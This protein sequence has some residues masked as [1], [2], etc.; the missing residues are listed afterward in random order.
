[1]RAPDRAGDDLGVAARL[2]QSGRDAETG[3]VEAGLLERRALDVVARLGALGVVTDP[4]LVGAVVPVD[5]LLLRVGEAGAVVDVPERRAARE[6]E[7]ATV[8][9]NLREGEQAVPALQFEEVVVEH[10]RRRAPAAR[11]HERLLRRVPLVGHAR[12]RLGD[13]LRVAVLDDLVVVGRLADR[14]ERELLTQC[15]RGPAGG[16]VRLDVE[17]HE[18]AVQR[19]SGVHEVD[20][21]AVTQAGGVVREHDRPDPGGATV[22][23][24]R[25]VAA[26]GTAGEVDP[27]RAATARGG[28]DLRLTLLLRLLLAVAL[29]VSLGL[30]LGGGGG[31]GV[32][33]LAVLGGLGAVGV[34]L[35][36]ATDSGSEFRR[37]L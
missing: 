6:L 22:L 13:V 30:L 16:L 5:V 10:L 36:L 24:G 28:D 26:A 11:R 7:A 4:G 37:L 34:L 32:L 9:A 3:D 18:T 23:L 15:P 33:A 35:A 19:A 12:Q 2:E 25:S 31:L 14:G 20:G 21:L 1:E 27:D 17:A 29:A 8:H